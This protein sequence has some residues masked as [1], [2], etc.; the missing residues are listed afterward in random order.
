MF[1]A[2]SIV[3]MLWLAF[4]AVRG[5]EPNNGRDDS[6]DARVA[7]ALATTTE[8]AKHYQFRMSGGDRTKTLDFH[9]KSVLRWSNP[10]IGV[11]YGNVFVW[12]HEGR[13]E[14]I[15]SLL[16][17]Y[18]PFKHGTHEFH[19]LSQSQ[20]EGTRD[21]AVIWEAVPPGIRRKQVPESPIV[22]DS[23]LTRLRQMRAIARQFKIEST[24]RDA[25]TTDLR[26]LSQP[27]FRYGDAKSKVIEGALFSFVQGTDPE[28]ILLVEARENESGSL[29]WNYGL[30]RMATLK[31]VA[32]YQSREVWRVEI[33]PFKEAMAGRG[34]YTLLRAKRPKAAVDDRTGNKPSR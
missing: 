10:V 28:V 24:N 34:A 22:G 21:G 15:G 32:H 13:P 5:D 8:A 19:S 2:F 27:I 7:E 30:M 9:P 25:K 23:P 29:E 33:L 6:A 14:V 26:L 31:F 16:Q 1:R 17:W 3:S 20:V 11:V 4:G 12:T 18:S